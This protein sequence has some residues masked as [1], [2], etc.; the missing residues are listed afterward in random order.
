MKRVAQARGI[1]EEE[2][3]AVLKENTAEPLLGFI[4]PAK[5]NVLKLNV[6]LDER[7]PSKDC[8]VETAA[9]D[10]SSAVVEKVQNDTI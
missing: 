9:P 4:G 6:A 8:L 2:V 10:D 1:A 3:L 5:V 7:Y